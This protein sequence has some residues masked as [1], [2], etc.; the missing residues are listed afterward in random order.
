MAKQT[1]AL[2]VGVVWSELAHG[3]YL[4]APTRSARRSEAQNARREGQSHGGAAAAR[5]GGAA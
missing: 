3:V 5:R 2:T 4:R 1:E